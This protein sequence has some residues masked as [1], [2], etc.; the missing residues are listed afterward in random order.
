MELLIA[1]GKIFL[2][3]SI[4]AVIMLD[5]SETTVL[6]IK[7]KEECLIAFGVKFYYEEIVTF[8]F[9]H[10]YKEELQDFFFVMLYHCYIG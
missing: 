3:F 5:I 8:F 1:F 9:K 7:L 2:Q 10:K 4:V 6:H